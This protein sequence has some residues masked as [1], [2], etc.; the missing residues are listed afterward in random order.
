MTVYTGEPTLLAQGFFALGWELVGPQGADGSTPK[1]PT[2]RRPR[3]R[4][5]DAQGADA[6]R[7]YPQVE[8]PY[9]TSRFTLSETR[10]SRP[11]HRGLGHIE[12][13]LGE[14]SGRWP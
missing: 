5:A 14:G 10:F 6:L 9:S 1:G 11:R 4:R 2:G 12:I 8:S 3:G 13:A 7:P